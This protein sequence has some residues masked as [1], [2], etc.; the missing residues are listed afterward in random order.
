M[1]GQCRA[2]K[3]LYYYDKINNDCKIFT[4]GGCGGNNNKYRTEMECLETCSSGGT[5]VCDEVFTTIH[6]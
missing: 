5:V 3:E 6:K 2:R 1:T 4:Y